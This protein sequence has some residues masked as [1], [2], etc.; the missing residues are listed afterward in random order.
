MNYL[1]EGIYLPLSLTSY[2]LQV[3]SI[4]NSITLKAPQKQKT[5]FT[6]EKF[7]VEKNKGDAEMKANHKYIGL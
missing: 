5:K 7:I 1:T 2:I 3:R 6:L 4:N